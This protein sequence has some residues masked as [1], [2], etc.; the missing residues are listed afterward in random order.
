MAQLEV[1]HIQTASLTRARPAAADASR[2]RHS[3]CHARNCSQSQY[4]HSRYSHSD[5]DSGTPCVVSF[6]LEVCSID[7]RKMGAKR[8]GGGKDDGAGS[9]KR[10][11]S[12][13]ASVLVCP[14]S[15]RRDASFVFIRGVV[16]AHASTPQSAL[17][18][19]DKPIVINQWDG[20][21]VKNTLDD[22]VHKYTLDSLDG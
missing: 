8:R 5:R 6:S 22:C 4:A 16:V 10:K 7:G 21:T 2:R 9:G 19:E 15:E 14:N 20:A 17:D 1:A 3:R 13:S 18:I 11:S 12:N